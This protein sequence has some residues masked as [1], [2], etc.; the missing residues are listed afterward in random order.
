[1]KI[2]RSN[3]KCL[4]FVNRK[5]WHRQQESI[6]FFH[7]LVSSRVWIVSQTT[8]LRQCK[9]RRIHEVIRFFRVQLTLKK[10]SYKKTECSSKWKC[11]CHGLCNLFFGVLLGMLLYCLISGRLYMFELFSFIFISRLKTVPTPSKLC[12]MLKTLLLR[13]KIFLAATS[14]LLPLLPKQPSILSQSLKASVPIHSSESRDIASAFSLFKDY[15]DK[16]LGALHWS[17]I[18]KTSCAVIPI[19]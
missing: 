7:L 16:K 13:T 5:I 17:A 2:D 19:L 11:I 14:N 4:F 3:R 6:F 15:F 18:F 10:S 1:M 8:L 9:W 12:M